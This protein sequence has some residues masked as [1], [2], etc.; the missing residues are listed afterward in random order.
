VLLLLCRAAAAAAAVAARSCASHALWRSRSGREAC[1][2]SCLP[3]LRWVRLCG[4]VWFACHVT[5][6]VDS[7]QWCAWRR[8][9]PSCK[10][11]QKDSLDERYRWMC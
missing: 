1:H 8:P 6:A 4:D 3:W 2:P 5:L 10:D 11:A 7:A 9:K